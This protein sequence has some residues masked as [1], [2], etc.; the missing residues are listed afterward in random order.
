MRILGQRWT[1]RIGNTLVEVDNAFSWSMWGQ[2]RM[3]VNGEV[4]QQSS[5][6][7]RFH[8]QY[9]EPWL[10]A[11][12]EGELKIELKARGMGIACAATLDG[13][14]VYPEATATAR[15]RGPRHSWPDADD[16]ESRPSGNW[17][18]ATPTAHAEIGIADHRG[19]ARSLVD[20]PTG[21]GNRFRPLFHVFGAVCLL[22][23]VGSLAWK[24]GQTVWASM[25]AS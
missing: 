23:A 12:G 20:R 14:H 21:P 24:L 18:A 11:T 10:T 19:L 6:G 25:G 5:G 7:M 1:Y 3:I 2:E 8:Q 13:E 9:K 16:W 17:S 22:I 15:W 4:V